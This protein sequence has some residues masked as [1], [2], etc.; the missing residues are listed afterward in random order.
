M[1]VLGP[2]HPKV[3]SVWFSGGNCVLVH[4]VVPLRLGTIQT[5]AVVALQAVDGE[6]QDPVTHAPMPIPLDGFL[7]QY[8]G[9]VDLPQCGEV[10][11]APPSVGHRWRPGRLGVVTAIPPEVA[12]IKVE[13]ASVSP[14]FPYP[15][16]LF[17]QRWTLVIPLGRTTRVFHPR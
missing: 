14:W 2:E 11:R 9:P 8:R 16:P 13:M 12:F 4:A 6:W 3:G 10:W 1:E 17:K 15:P 5:W 7:A